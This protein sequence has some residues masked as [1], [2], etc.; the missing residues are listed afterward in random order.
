MNIYLIKPLID[1][2]KDSHFYESAVVIAESAEQA[3]QMHPFN[4]NTPDRRDNLEARFVDGRW[5][6]FHKVSGRLW[7]SDDSWTKAPT[8]VDVELI[9][10]A[11][12]DN[13][14]PQVVIASY[15]G[16]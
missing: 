11:L 15:V 13:V 8:L 12:S 2:D 16:G 5:S 1:E 14:S 7:G 3:A 4:F 9:G 6:I 10:E